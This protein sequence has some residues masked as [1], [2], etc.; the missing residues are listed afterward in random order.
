MGGEVGSKCKNFSYYSFK[1][2]YTL[3]LNPVNHFSFTFLFLILIN[4]ATLY[5][6]LHASYS[7]W[8]LMTSLRL[9]FFFFFL[10]DNQYF[11]IFMT[12]ALYCHEHITQATLF[13][14]R[15]C[16]PYPKN[17]PISTQ[18]FSSLS[19]TSLCFHCSWLMQWKCLKSKR[20]KRFSK[21]K[22]QK[23][24]EEEKTLP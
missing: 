3:N 13:F 24:K 10:A 19:F 20:R 16:M 18:T 5:H 9:H 14:I 7:T 23:K 21:E 22:K 11:R 8:K 17:I 1:S 6:N 15:V 12:K 4:L 2:Y